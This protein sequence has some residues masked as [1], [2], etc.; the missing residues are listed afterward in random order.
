MIKNFIFFLIFLFVLSGF[1]E[2]VLIERRRPQF[3]KEHGYYIIPA[4]Y[5]LPGHG[6]GLA[7]A[8]VT[9][10]I[11]NTYTDIYGFAL[12]GDLA[13]FGGAVADIHLVPETLILDLNAERFNKAK[14]ANYSQRG[15]R[16]EIYGGGYDFGSRIERIRDNSGKIIL[17]AENSATGGIQIWIL[18]TRLD[19]TDDY[20]DP[21]KGFRFDV[22]GW[23]SPPKR[24]ASPDYYILDYNATAYIPIGIRNT[25]IFN[26][27]RSDAH[28]IRKGETDRTAIE[29]EQGLACSSIADPEKQKLCLQVI[30]N[31]IAANTY[32]TASGL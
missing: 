1:S 7:I 26:Y 14:I 3:Q 31:T 2:A 5:S 32:G 13:G 15:R 30:D 18:G 11:S 17:E 12:T 16:F 27:F 21:R 10:N 8:A 25:W 9:T 20:S 24:S 22:S 29:Q 6:Q 4:P 28:I 19:I 23:W